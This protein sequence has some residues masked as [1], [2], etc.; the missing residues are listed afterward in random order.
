MQAELLF[1]QKEERERTSL[2]HK[3]DINFVK[4]SFENL[5]L[6]SDAMTLRECSNLREHQNRFTDQ[7]EDDRSFFTNT[8]TGQRIPTRG[9]KNRNQGRTLFLLQEGASDS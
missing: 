3:S 1:A 8:R 7:D 4:K 9:L 2:S 5:N 6:N